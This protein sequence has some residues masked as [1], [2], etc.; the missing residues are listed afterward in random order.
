[1]I[2]LTLLYVIF[3]WAVF[4]WLR[5]VPANTWTILTAAIL[6]AGAIGF[7]VTMM[8][9]YQ[10]ATRDARFIFY[11]TAIISEVNGRIIEVPVKTHQPLKKGDVLARLDPEPFQ[12]QVKSAQASLNLAQR[13]LRFL[14][15]ELARNEQLLPSKAVAVEQVDTARDQRDEARD[16]VQAAEAQLAIAQHNLNH[17]VITAPT[18]GYVAQLLVR[19]G[20][21]TVPLPFAPLMVF[22]HREPDAFVAAFPQNVIQSVK[23]GAPVEV[24]FPFSPGHVFKAKVKQVAAVIAEGQILANGELKSFT[25]HVPPGKVPVLL[26]FEAG[27]L[28]PLALPGGAAGEATV[29]T[30]QFPFT[31][32]LRRILFRMRSWENYVFAG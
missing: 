30:G 7:L 31:N 32:I 17:S 18:D 14:E 16:K 28:D 10:P 11:S 20:F 19:P 26:E 2:E 12:N 24:F 15:L 6:G 29:Y 27:E 8:N 5:L 9:F 3:C 25:A 13:Q 4:K 22:V 1:M 21:M 23:P